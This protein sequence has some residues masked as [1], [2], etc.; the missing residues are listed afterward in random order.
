MRLGG[1]NKRTVHQKKQDAML[2][3]YDAH[4][5]EV[6]RYA[7]IKT[8]DEDIAKDIV[9]ETF[10]KTWK[11]IQENEVKNIRALLY[12]TASNLVIDYYRVKPRNI[13]LLDDMPFEALPRH[14]PLE[15]RV[16]T[17][18]SFE[19]ARAHLQKLPKDYREVF[20][21][22]FIQ[23]LEPK[24]ISRVTGKSLGNIYVILH[25]G[26]KALKEELKSHE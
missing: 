2:Q 10:L 19:R 11:Y 3:A 18:I 16:D 26:L 25:R 1:N 4:A 20:T 17:A 13:P 23:D 22:R 6:L 5:R 14:V 12:K 15:D 8:G 7:T 9:S 21:L 24:E